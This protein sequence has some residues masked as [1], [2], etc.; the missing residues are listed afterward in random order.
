MSGV[1]TQTGGQLNDYWVGFWKD[2]KSW[3]ELIASKGLPSMS[4]FGDSAST[5]LNMTKL[6]VNVEI[7]GIYSQTTFFMTFY[8][9]TNQRLSGELV[10]PLPD[11]AVVSGYVRNVFS[12]FRV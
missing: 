7:N 9:D 4:A 12:P 6:N 3:E 10:F 8:N 5:Q 2:R 11:G 1:S